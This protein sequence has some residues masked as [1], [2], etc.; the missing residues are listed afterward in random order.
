[1]RV[2]RWVDLGRSCSAM[3]DL[4][5]ISA[6]QISI[7]RCCSN[8]D[9][10]WAVHCRVWTSPNR[11]NRN[12]VSKGTAGT[13]S[14]GLG[15]TFS[16]QLWLSESFYFSALVEN[17]ARDKSLCWLDTVRF[18]CRNILWFFQKLVEI[19]FETME[20]QLV[21]CK[22]NIFQK[23]V[24]R[25]PISMILPITDVLD[26]VINDFVHQKDPATGAIRRFRLH[27]IKRDK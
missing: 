21:S 1:M 14:L 18:I 27:S 5:C 26:E 23:H 13:P 20:S 22:T 16:S 4:D 9:A 6:K 10:I 17:V 12:T 8:W 3:A 25:Y 7:A 19:K 11:S 15:P 24:K 2:G